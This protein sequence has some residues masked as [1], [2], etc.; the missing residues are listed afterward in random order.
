MKYF[1]ALR[2]W[3]LFITVYLAVLAEIEFAFENFHTFLA[4]MGFSFNVLVYNLVSLKVMHSFEG[5][6][7]CAGER[8]FV[9]V[10]Y[11]VLQ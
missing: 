4:F 7:T 11:L 9:T 10:G 1:V 8:S 2:T 5:F 6:T 3:E